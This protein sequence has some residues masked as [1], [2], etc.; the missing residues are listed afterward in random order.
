MFIAAQLL[1]SVML[2]AYV[3]LLPKVL[4]WKV[5]VGDAFP[6]NVS[7][8]TTVYMCASTTPHPGQKES[9]GRDVPQ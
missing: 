7:C 5:V 9:S 8:P 1:S 4:S 2:L 3:M 6:K